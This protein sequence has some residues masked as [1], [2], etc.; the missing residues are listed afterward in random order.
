[1]RGEGDAEA[2]PPMLAFEPA[3]VERREEAFRAPILEAEQRAEA[4]LMDARGADAVGGVEAVGEV[5]LPALRVVDVVGLAVVR[6]LVDEHGVQAVAAELGVVRGLHRLN[7]EGERREVRAEQ[8]EGLDEVGDLHLVRL[9]RQDQQV[10][11][12]QLLEG[13][14]LA[15]DLAGV[16]R[17][18][19][20]LVA[21]GEAAVGADV[22]ALVG[23]VSRCEELHRATVAADRALM[24]QAGHP[25]Q[26]RG[27]RRRDQ[28]LEVLEVGRIRFGAGERA[29]HVR[30][31]LPLDRGEN[32]VPGMGGMDFGEGH[33]PGWWAK[34]LAGQG[35]A[36]AQRIAA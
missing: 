18:P 10:V 16:Q 24:A 31:R 28:R 21:R 29:D 30:L 6:L 13:P 3:E 19:R 12:A 1:M 17:A 9:A 33:R 35:L 25:F 2:A 26:M 27:R 8:V 32:L 14:G 22:L 4:D 15:E 5:R 7:L 20:D 23:E 34:S 11:E 36:A